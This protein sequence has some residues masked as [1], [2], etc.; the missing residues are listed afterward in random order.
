LADFTIKTGDTYPPLGA[1]LDDDGT[2]VDLTA[3]DSVRLILKLESP[4]TVVE[5]AAAVTSAAGGAVEYEWAAG[6]TDQAGEYQGEWE[7]T[8]DAGSTPPSVQTFPND[9]YFSVEILADLD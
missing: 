3:A 2:P 4:S 8:W 7:V 6:D 9:G 5:G 1:V